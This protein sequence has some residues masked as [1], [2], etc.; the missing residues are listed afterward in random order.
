MKKNAIIF[1]KTSLMLLFISFQLNAQ[2]ATVTIETANSSAESK[3]ATEANVLLA[4]LNEIKEMDKSNL[5]SSDKK[6]LR[7][8]VK[9]LRSNLK[10]KSSGVYLSVGAIII[11]I[12]LLILLL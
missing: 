5:T 2:I 11:I 4:R 7:K 3:A 12:L 1:I 9:S 6:E 10:E 8:E